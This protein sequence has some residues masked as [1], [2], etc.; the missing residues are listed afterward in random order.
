M[1]RRIASYDYFHRIN[2]YI[3]PSQSLFAWKAGGEG[4]TEID[5]LQKPCLEAIQQCISKIEDELKKM[6]PADR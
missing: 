6:Q 3:P 4:Q 1:R 2:H 5:R